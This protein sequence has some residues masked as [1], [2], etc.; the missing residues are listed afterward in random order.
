MLAQGGAPGGPIERSR[1]KGS[2]R[3]GPGSRPR[4]GDARHREPGDRAR[5][6]V[7]PTTTARRRGRRRPSRGSADREGHRSAVPVA[8]EPDHQQ[9]LVERAAPVRPRRR[10]DRGPRSVRRARSRPRRGPRRSPRSG[11]SGPGR[12]RRPGRGLP[13]V[14]GVPGVPGQLHQDRR[15]RGRPAE[16]Q[17]GQGTTIGARRRG[18]PGAAT[19]RSTVVTGPRMG[20]VAGDVLARPTSGS[21]DAAR[22]RAVL[23]ATASRD[24]RPPAVGDRVPRSAYDAVRGPDRPPRPAR[25]HQ[26]GCG[27]AGEHGEATA[28]ERV[29][30]AAPC[31]GAAS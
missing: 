25:R 13:E 2:S 26:G 4:P 12:P 18:S 19:G 31:R 6:G 14:T 30:T 27:E 15:G 24:G 17:P 11:P 28:Q 20:Q 16:G 22:R 9:R 8:A 10:H 21:A 23:S 29:R 5:V 7:R 3:S 1:R